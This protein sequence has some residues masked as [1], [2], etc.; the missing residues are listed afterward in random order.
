MKGAHALRRE[1]QRQRREDGERRPR[2]DPFGRLDRPASSAS[3]A[4]VLEDVGAV[5][6]IAGAPVTVGAST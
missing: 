4:L 3:N 1:Q 5:A 6:R 2:Y